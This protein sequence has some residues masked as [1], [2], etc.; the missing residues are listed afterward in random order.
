MHKIKKL[1]EVST[2]NEHY[3]FENLYINLTCLLNIKLSENENK[4]NTGTLLFYHFYDKNNKL[5]KIK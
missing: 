1:E 4:L 5:P 2:I 3:G